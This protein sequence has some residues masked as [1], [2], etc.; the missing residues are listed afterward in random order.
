MQTLIQ[1]T[2]Q[3]YSTQLQVLTIFYLNESKKK[4]HLIRSWNFLGTFLD[5]YQIDCASRDTMA[6]ASLMTA[7]LDFEMVVYVVQDGPDAF[8]VVPELDAS[9]FVVVRQRMECQSVVGHT[10]SFDGGFDEPSKANLIKYIN[11]FF[12][13][14][15]NKNIYLDKHTKVS[16]I[17]VTYTPLYC[18][19]LLCNHK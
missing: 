11:K 7:N 12:L 17:V 16:S 15:L 5:T 1:Q 6:M 13:R 9:W 10:Y 2:T 4:F 19:I 14:K 3:F 8:V 18:K